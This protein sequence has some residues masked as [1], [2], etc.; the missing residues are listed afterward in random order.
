MADPKT[1]PKEGVL[2]LVG[3]VVKKRLGEFAKEAREELSAGVGKFKDE[4]RSEL[5]GAQKEEE[6]AP[7]PQPGVRIQTDSD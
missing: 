1:D 5:D 7:A 2:P 4:L 3:R 6:E